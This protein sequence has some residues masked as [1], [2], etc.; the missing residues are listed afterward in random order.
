MKCSVIILN[1]NGV[2][3]LRQYLPSVLANTPKDDIEVV[4][5]DNGSTD[6]SL[7]WLRTQPVRLIV[8][9]KNYGFAGGY[10]RAIA[11]VDSQY[12]VLLNSDVEVPQGWLTPLLQCLDMNADVAAVQPKVLSWRSWQQVQNGETDTPLFEHA[13]AA[14]GQIDALGYPYCRGRLLSFIEHDKGQYDTPIDVFWATGACMAVNR[15]VY[16]AL[17]GLDEYFFAHQEEIDLCWRM[18]CRGYR[19]KCEPQAVIYHLG[20]GTLSYESPR[21]T[22][23]NFRNNLLML[24][25]NLPTNRLWWVMIVRFILDY[26]AALQ[27]LLTGHTSNFK[28]VVQARHDYLHARKHYQALRQENMNAAVCKFPKTI[29]HRSIIWDYYVRGKRK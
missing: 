16:M 4:V 11:Q 5:A 23:L 25:K 27:M 17:G 7:E 8:L 22:Y 19:V 20:A 2:Q 15:A 13:G 29:T 18:Q 3:M 24:Y 9:D 10:N 12:V 28:A 26:V 14:G 1:W 6:G 21:K